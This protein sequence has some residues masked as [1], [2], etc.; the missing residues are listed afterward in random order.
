VGAKGGGMSISDSGGGYTYDPRPIVEQLRR[1]LAIR[2]VVGLS[3]A[4]IL[5]VVVRWIA[6]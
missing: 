5:L 4:G 3:A 2:I 1:R 6:S